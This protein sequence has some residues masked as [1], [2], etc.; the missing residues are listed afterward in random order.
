MWD[1]DKNNKILNKILRSIE[2]Y[3]TSKTQIR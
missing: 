3:F 2:I 1:D